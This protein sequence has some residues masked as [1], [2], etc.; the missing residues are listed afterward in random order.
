MSVRYNER[1]W[2]IDVISKINEYTISTNRPVRHASG[3]FTLTTTSGKLFPDVLLYGDAVTGTILQ[4]WEMKFPDTPITDSELID[5][6]RKK[7]ISLGTN[8]FLLWNVSSAVLYVADS[9]GIF[10]PSKTWNI[11]RI[12]R[13]ED[14]YHNRDAW[15]D[16]LKEILEDV[17][18]LLEDGKLS[19]ANITE[20]FNEQTLYEIISRNTDSVA[21]QLADLCKNDSH[22]DAQVNI[23]WGTASDEYPQD[24]NPL[25]V[26][27]RIILM[28]WI[29]KFVFAHILK[30]YYS[31]ARIVD[32]FT[33]DTTPVEAQ[34]LFSRISETCDFWNIF[35]D[36][37]GEHALTGHAWQ[38]L[39][40]LNNFLK[41]IRFEEIEQSILHKLLQN[42][43]FASKRKAAGQYATPKKLASLLLRIVM[44][45]KT[46]TFLDPCCGT[47][48]ISKA[49]Y[50]IKR[51]YGIA[52]KVALSQI[53]ASDK[54]SFPLQIASLALSEPSNM[55]ELLQ[56][57]QQDVATLRPNTTVILNDPYNGEVMPQTMPKIT[58]IASN[59]PF[60]QFED[61]EEYN[62]DI[63]AI[64]EFIKEV[65]GN[66]TTITKK[67]D[68]YAYIPFCL[69]R[70]LEDD[71]KMGIIVSNSWSGTAWGE[72]FQKLLRQFFHVQKVII[73]GAGKWFT[74]SD[75]ITTLIV[76]KKRNTPSQPNESEET[77]F[78]TLDKK[79]E[80]IDDNEITTI[81]SH[82]LTDMV[83]DKL[84]SIQ[85]KTIV[86]INKLKKLGMGMNAMF[87]DLNWMERLSEV[88]VPLSSRLQITR[89]ERRG[90]NRMFYP[91]GE[92]NVEPDYIKSVLK[93]PKS[94][95]GFIA[96][97][98][99]DAFCCS[100]TKDELRQLRHHGALSWIARFEHGVNTKGE[101]LIET[102]Q[103]SAKKG[104]HWYEM[105]DDNKA[106]FVIP[107]N[108]DKR[109][110][111]PKI[112]PR[113]FI[114]QRLAGLTMINEQDD[115]MLY[116]AILNSVM[117]MFYIEA[118]GFGRGLGALDLSAQKI[119]DHMYMLNPDLLTESQSASIKNA[120]E[121]VLKRDALPLEEELNR[122]ERKYFDDTVLKAYGILSLKP[123]IVNALL[124][125]YKT[126]MSVKSQ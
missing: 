97:P 34:I 107:I 70:V 55:G 45:N 101:P 118:L 126:R 11:P 74:N 24:D 10:Q 28:S 44:E 50:D 121:P 49:A 17:N 78:V 16:T 42:T 56:I 116:H 106:D 115:A 104:H 87:V 54:F 2:A 58:Y 52:S 66:N 86:T 40:Q 119:D 113:T 23:W 47:G 33:E 32:N 6:A 26:L 117:G 112:E 75:V 81:A 102:L 53:W 99:A 72:K 100:K 22:F 48:T 114:D 61:I 94:V 19:P 4:G 31:D 20:I 110:F 27:A 64:N 82:I 124:R 43:V 3:E 62:P 21:Q 8:S 12:T 35:R 13:R 38:Q 120:F 63:Y 90:W 85:K 9:E 71:G 7:A 46:S 84:C 29:N 122:P 103:A 92:H 69:W 111:I 68:L 18:D 14:V 60:V 80:H 25:P 65:T 76:L 95:K 98:D 37:I 105:R 57:F 1:S 30:R 91:T 59:L 36:L 5:N 108:F 109:L 93:S 123:L 79:L 89:G 83:D 125:L 77:S 15:M 73:S 51:E 41:S 67:S 39:L 96:T 88:L